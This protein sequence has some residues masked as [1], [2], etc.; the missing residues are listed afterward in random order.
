LKAELAAAQTVLAEL[1]AQ[2]TTHD[3][4]VDAA[5]AHLQS[6]VDDLRQRRK[7][8]DAERQDLKAKSKML[9][10]QKRQA[11]GARR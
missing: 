10:D 4:S 6:T 8:D 1:Q 9:E 3:E 2:L 7:E 11:E 5:H